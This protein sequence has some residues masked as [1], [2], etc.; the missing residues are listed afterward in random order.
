MKS[1]EKPKIIK[2]RNRLFKLLL[3]RLD[4][5]LCWVFRHSNLILKPKMKRNRIVTKIR[6]S[7]QNWRLTSKKNRNWF[8]RMSQMLLNLTTWKKRK[9]IIYKILLK[10]TQYKKKKKMKWQRLHLRVCQVCLLGY[11]SEVQMQFLT[12][13]QT[14][15]HQLT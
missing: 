3:L 1:Q 2:L 10:Q 13:I 9:R 8:N 15:E 14:T 7:H 12:S 11:L 4:L 6:F 5:L